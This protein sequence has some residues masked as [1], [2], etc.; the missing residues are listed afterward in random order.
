MKRLD[1]KEVK[2]KYE[3]K[4]Y[5]RLSEA[6]MTVGEGVS[7]SDVFRV[8]KD[9]VTAVAAEVDTEGSKEENA[10]WTDEIQEAIEVKRR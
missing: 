2:E 9:A 4:V 3:R 7:V 6:R 8:L 10:G 5:E 1:R